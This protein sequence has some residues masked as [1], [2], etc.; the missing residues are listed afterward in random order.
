MIVEEMLQSSIGR[1]KGY[2]VVNLP[3]I[4][5]I[6]WN[7]RIDTQVVFHFC[8]FFFQHRGNIGISIGHLASVLHRIIL[9][10]T[11]N[12][13]LVPIATLY[14]VIMYIIGEQQVCTC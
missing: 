5:T 3:S 7:Q 2:I 13:V 14:I 11:E 8:I 6:L 9:T 12:T 1:Y 10:Q 4:F